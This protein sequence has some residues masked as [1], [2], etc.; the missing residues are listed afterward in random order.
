MATE[1]DASPLKTGR[2]YLNERGWPAAKHAPAAGLR[3]V[4]D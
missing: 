2:E 4:A 1:L 3:G